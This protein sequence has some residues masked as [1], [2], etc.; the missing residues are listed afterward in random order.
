MARRP[1]FLPRE[2]GGSR[3]YGGHLLVPAPA[4]SSPHPTRTGGAGKGRSHWGCWSSGVPRVRAPREPCPRCPL[5]VMLGCA[6]WRLEP[7]T[8]SKPLPQGLSADTA[9]S[10]VGCPPSP[11]RGEQ[12]RLEP[13][14]PPAPPCTGRRGPLLFKP[15]PLRAG[16]GGEA[17]CSPNWLPDAAADGPGAP[18]EALSRW[19]QGPPC[20]AT[21]LCPRPDASASPVSEPP[22]ERNDLRGT[23]LL[24][25]PGGPLR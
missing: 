25:V 9:A 20:R 13:S 14:D 3:V 1:C 7:H 24:L 16:R 6:A 12:L 15:H 21:V 23:P 5:G 11:W 17:G 10:P 2:R 22:C 18:G 19:R 8:V 4:L